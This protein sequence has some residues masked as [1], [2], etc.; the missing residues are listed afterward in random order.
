MVLEFDKLLTHLFSQIQLV[1]YEEFEAELTLAIE[2]M[3][4]IDLKD[5]PFLAVGI[6]LGLDGIWTMDN[7]FQK[8]DVLPVFSTADLFKIFNSI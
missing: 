4:D 5:A 2:V 7:D 1:N 3:K 8:Q 6:A